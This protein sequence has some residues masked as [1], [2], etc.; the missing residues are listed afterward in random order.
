MKLKLC[1][2][3]IIPIICGCISMPKP[4]DEAYLSEINQDESA[5]LEKIGA[6][7]ITK[8]QEKDKTE[9]DHEIALQT[10][11]VVNKEIAKL[12]SENDLLV[13]KEKLYILTGDNNKISNVQKRN[14]DNKIKIEQTNAYLKYNKAKKYETNSLLDLKKNEL[15][16]KVAELDY[17]K[18][19]IAKEYQMKRAQ[20][21][22]GKIIDELKYKKFVDDQNIKLDDNKKKYDKA[23][24]ELNS[25]EEEL[26]KS[27]YEV[28]K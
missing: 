11:E 9:K 21:F 1:I 16:L 18:A 27:G 15:A 19:L 24:K 22:E 10:I 28:E 2:L 3:L 17:E 20:E 6:D 13:E 8:K 5:K 14:A 25:A 23:L 4:I 26:K 7:I 12:E